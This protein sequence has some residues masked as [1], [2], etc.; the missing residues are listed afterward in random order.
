MGARVRYLKRNA[1]TGALSYRRAFPEALRLYVPGGPANELKRGLGSDTISDPKALKAFA[2]AGADYEQMH[3]L[4]LKASTATFDPLDDPTIAFLAETYRVNLLAKDEAIRRREIPRGPYDNP[5]HRAAS[6]DFWR[7]IA[8]NG[9]RAQILG[10]LGDEAT[11]LA[12]AQG[13]RVNPSSPAFNRLC[14][15]LLYVSVAVA[16]DVT[17]RDR[18]H[19]VPTPPAPSLGSQF[20]PAS[21]AQSAPAGDTLEEVIAKLLDRPSAPIAN[22]TLQV[23]RTASRSFT[24]IN[25]PLPLVAVTRRETSAWM[26]ALVLK[27]TPATLPPKHRQLPLNELIELYPQGAPVPRIGVLTRTA[28]VSALKSIWTKAAQAGLISEDLRNPFANT[29]ITALPG[30]RSAPEVN[31]GFTS[32]D[33]TAIF[34]LPVF[35]Q[36]ERPTQGR[37]E[38]AYWLPLLLL[39]TGARPE[40]VAQLLVS[41]FT[42]DPETGL[43]MVTFTDVGEHPVKGRRSLK[44]AKKGTGRRV[45]PVPQELIRIGLPAYLEALQ[46]AGETALFPK[47]TMVTSRGLNTKWGEWWSSY[48]RKHGALPVTGH[49]AARDFRHTW[50]TAARASGIGERERE[51]IQG[52]SPANSSANVGY[53]S[54]QV[55][56][57]AIERLELKGLDLSHLS[58]L[59][60]TAS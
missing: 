47:L 40:E 30:E 38:A 60:P 32:A 19:P 54:R 36:G 1:R 13:L 33:L 58:W 46:E 35:T 31:P 29:R 44:T 42:P 15:K 11:A 18:D 52:H 56:G 14:D 10:F 21:P 57:L 39:W 16:D 20:G 53:G 4:A 43:L 25:G 28:Q 50:T 41:D 34:S 22:T 24:A 59:A 9:T 3:S 17:A 26:D 45:F 27:P 55:E 6:Q 7:E 37:G 2:A 49:K 12:A 23:W 48:L 8:A 51:Y 5:N